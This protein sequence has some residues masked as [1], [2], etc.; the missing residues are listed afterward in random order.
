MLTTLV[1]VATKTGENKHSCCQSL[2]K[3]NAFNK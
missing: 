2:K 1:K 3:T